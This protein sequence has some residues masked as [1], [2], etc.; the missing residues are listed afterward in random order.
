MRAKGRSEVAVRCHDGL[1]SAATQGQALKVS[2]NHNIQTHHDTRQRHDD[3][4]SQ[5]K[6]NASDHKKVYRVIAPTEG[7]LVC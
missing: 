5:R 6:Q 3:R 1:D 4:H 2:Y 7:W